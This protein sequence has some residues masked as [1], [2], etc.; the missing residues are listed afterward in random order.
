VIV[1]MPPFCT[2]QR[3]VKKIFAALHDSIDET[4]NTP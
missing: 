4:L 3:Q 2:T 1:I